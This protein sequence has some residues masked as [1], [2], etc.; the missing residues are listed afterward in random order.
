MKLNKIT[1]KE[2]EKIDVSQFKPIKNDEIIK[3]LD[4]TIKKDNDNKITTFL[5]CISAFTEDSQINISFNSPSSTGKSYTAL[6]V[7]KFFP[8]EDV[9]KLGNCSKT[10]FFHE[11]G[12]Y[13]KERNEITVDLSRKI[14]IFTDMPHTGLLESLRSFLSHDEKI[15]YSKITDKNQK[16]GNRTKTVALK[17]YPSV[18]FCSAG[19]KMDPQEMTRF[20]LLSPET[21]QEKMRAGISNTILKESDNDKFNEWLESNPER[22]LFKLRIQA[23]K[24][25][26]IGEIK[27][28]NYESIEKRFLYSDRVIQP[29]HLR[30]IKKLLSLIKSFAIINLWWRERNGNTITANDDDINEAFTL[31]DRISISQELNIP[32]YVYE[33][34]TR[35]FIP[36]FEEKNSKPNDFGF[37]KDGITRAEIMQKHFQVYKRRLNMNA[38]RFDIIPTLDSAGLITRE[39]DKNDAR[40]EII[41]I[42]DFKSVSEL[43]NNSVGGGGENKDSG[44]ETDANCGSV[45]DDIEF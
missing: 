30:D 18:I 45:L 32:P 43:E 8:S 44:E 3:V 40:K 13:D 2:P 21:D 33:L 14:L 15:M 20:I 38:L 24:Q 5:C 39:K 36:A 23:I 27:T 16:G 37:P 29:R 9:I 26:N 10:A 19:L 6:E 41:F 25:E 7:A 28:A 11:Q 34:Y 35:V 12:V 31:W 1:I 17:G 42:T 4:L 22:K